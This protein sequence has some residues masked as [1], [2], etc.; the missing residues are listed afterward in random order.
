MNNI[1][2][3]LIIWCRSKA[4]VYQRTYNTNGGGF[5]IG[6]TLAYELDFKLSTLI[7]KPFESADAFKNDVLDLMDVHY[8]PGILNPQ[9]RT[10]Q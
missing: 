1:I 9:N 2:N 7:D 3:H 4:D 5:G 6:S 10:A 8:E